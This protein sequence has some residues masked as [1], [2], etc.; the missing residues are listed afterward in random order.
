MRRA[1]TRNLG[2]HINVPCKNVFR[3]YFI[4]VVPNVDEPYHNNAQKKIVFTHRLKNIR[5]GID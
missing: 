1:H 5:E 4:Y 3:T 2:A